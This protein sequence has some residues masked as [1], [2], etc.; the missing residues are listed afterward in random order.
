[1]FSVVPSFSV[2]SPGFDTL[3]FGYHGVFHLFIHCGYLQ[4]IVRNG[5]LL[6]GIGYDDRG[7]VRDLCSNCYRLLTFDIS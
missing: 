4:R 3:R 1:M 5:H 7:Q 6:S 2:S